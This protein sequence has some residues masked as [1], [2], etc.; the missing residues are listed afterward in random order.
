[1]DE[2]KGP[3]SPKKPWDFRPGLTKESIDA[4]GWAIHKARAEC[5]E[6]H[7]PDKDTVWGYGCKVRD[8]TCYSIVELSENV[9][10]ICIL[11]SK[12]EKY[13]W[14]NFSFSIRGVSCK[15]YKGNLDKPSDRIKGHHTLEPMQP[16]LFRSV[17]SDEIVKDIIGRFIIETIP[18]TLP[19]VRI[20]FVVLN[21]N[22]V[23]I[24]RYQ[25]P[26]D[27]GVSKAYSVDLKGEEGRD[28]QKAKLTL[29]KRTP[30]KSVSGSAHHKKVG[31]RRGTGD[32]VRPDHGK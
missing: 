19:V 15:F 28:V 31:K 6:E 22:R 4:T 12:G 30:P 10:D 7:D 32:I 24:C 23:E 25:I 26:L 14:Q 5:S 8:R 16:S 21:E 27:Q 29:K 1:M 3:K 13:K 2:R 11:E 9:P 18:G 17:R 20:V